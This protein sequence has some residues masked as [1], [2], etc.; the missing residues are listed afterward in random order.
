MRIDDGRQKRI[1][2]RKSPE[3]DAYEDDEFY[4]CD[5]FHCGIVVRWEK[6]QR[7]MDICGNNAVLTFYPGMKFLCQGR[8]L[9]RTSCR[10]WWCGLEELGHEC[11]PSECQGVKEGKD[12]VWNKSDCGHDSIISVRLRYE[13]FTHL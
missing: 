9:R 12:H 1:L 7:K 5:K 3:Q 11:R 13:Q 2:E 4:E 8:G 6:R 10:C